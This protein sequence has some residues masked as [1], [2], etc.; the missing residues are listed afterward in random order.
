MEKRVSLIFDIVK[1]F[2]EK[3]TD[4]DVLVES[5]KGGIASNVVASLC[6]TKLK[7]KE[8]NKVC[9]EIS[10]FAKENNIKFE[11]SHKTDESRVK[12]IWCFSSWVDTPEKGINA[13]MQTIKILAELNLAQEDIK[14]FIKFLNDNIGEDVYGEEF[15][16]LLQDEASGKL[17]F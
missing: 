4:G 6:E 8:A 17:S 7:A 14:A 16:I 10:K 2:G 9:E 11:V 13:I 3:T 1:T 15:G 12:S 5:I